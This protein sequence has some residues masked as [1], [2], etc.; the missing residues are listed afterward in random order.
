MFVAVSKAYFLSKY[1]RLVYLD[2]LSLSVS[3][4]AKSVTALHNIQ[5]FVKRA[6]DI[7][8]VSLTVLPVVSI[9]FNV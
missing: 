2:Y 5:H 8:D 4:A 6:C 3:Y 9:V 7:Y 1:W